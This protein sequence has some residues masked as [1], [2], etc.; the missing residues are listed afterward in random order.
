M[1]DILWR[2]TKLGLAFSEPEK[3]RLQR[4]LTER[5]VS[6]TTRSSDAA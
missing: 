1:D 2:R 5:P 6:E 3:A 4:Y